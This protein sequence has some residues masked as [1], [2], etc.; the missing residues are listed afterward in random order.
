MFSKFIKRNR[1]VAEA[2][3]EPQ[4]EIAAGT[5]WENRLQK[6]MGNDTELL[7]LAIEAPSIDYK[8]SCVQ[9]LSGEDGLR[10][11]EREFRKRERRVHSLAKQRFETLVKQR[12]TRASASELIQSA[13]ALLEVSIIPANRLVELK[14]AWESLDPSLIEDEY[15]SR[16]AKL[17]AVLTELMRERGE[18]KR[19]VQAWS[20]AA[21][22]TLAE[23]SSACSGVVIASTGS[24]ELV[25]MLATAGENAQATLAAMPA[26][27]PSPMPEDSIAME[28]GAAIRTGLQNLALIETR[29]VVL[30]ELNPSQATQHA[31]INGEKSSL[32]AVIERWKEL[33]SLADKRIENALNSRFDECLRLLDEARGKLQKQ[34]SLIVREKSKAEMQER[35]QALI[36][37]ANA[38]ETALAA[39]NLTEAGKQFAILQMASGKDSAGAA[40]QTR[41]GALQSEFSRL[42]GWQH[43]GGGRVR[44]D[45][46]LEA[47][48]LATAMVM[49]E[50]SNQAKMPIKE[51]ANH[52]EQ[53]RVRWKELDRLGGATSKSLWQRFDGALKTAYLPVAA[54]LAQL[55]EA[56][57]ENLSARKN[58]LTTLDAMSITAE[59]GKA[60]DWKVMER[61]L[62]HFQAEWRKL[63]PLEYTVPHKSQPALLDHMKASVA[64][65]EGP[66]KEMQINAQ[67]EREQLIARAKALSQDTQ[68]KDIVGKL[69]ELQA[70]W[71]SHA[72]LQPLPRKIENLLWL[73][74]KSV[75]DAIMSQRKAALSARDAEFNA[76]QTIREALVARL[77]N[78]HQDTPPAD[79]KRDLASV[80][81]E[82]R[83]AGE[84]PGNQVARLDSRYRAAREKAHEY[85]EGSARR[86]WQLNCDTLLAKL[87]LCEELESATP[88][89]IEARWNNLPA[90]PALWEQVLQVRYNSHGSNQGGSNPVNSGETL[91]ELLLQLELS[92]EITSPE[93]F[94][95]ARQTLKLLAMKNAIERR[96]TA[97]SFSIDIEQTTAAALAYTNLS[98]DQRSR[99]QSI[100]A[101][102]RRLAPLSLK[103]S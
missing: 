72:R 78:L 61:A 47:E 51:L 53:L 46:V 31:D 76:N 74:F 17:Q 20:T 80:D 14:R 103:T 88:A 5:T 68:G 38:M 35:I 95:K 82:W 43:W 16:F 70:E 11:A 42:K 94:R 84:A 60:P 58:L 29:L 1:A 85:L 64:R 83:K 10:Q 40:L 7:A 59:G 67:V 93:A 86:S 37:A 91:D 56:R 9:A 28:L 25:A 45:L 65:L 100:I 32:S 73:E 55:N 3:P 89:D 33:S 18:H 30:G 97:T 6:A 69:R 50:R 87:A 19:A 34:S 44:D 96:G 99:L 102:L 48:A 62:T 66:L 27:T 101:A 90:L 13:A 77:E 98:P 71:Q 21:R 92:L 52:I 54:H 4:P 41:I 36:T 63:G 79:I 26:T 23:L 12:E 75:T 39:G 22:Q 49:P 57:Q 15:K 24:Q 8:L 2:S 81:N